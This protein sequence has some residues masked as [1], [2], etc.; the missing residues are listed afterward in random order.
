MAGRESRASN[1]PSRRRLRSCDGPDASL[2]PKVDQRLDFDDGFLG[3]AGHLD[4]ILDH[5]PGA[6][7]LSAGVTSSVLVGGSSPVIIRE[8]TRSR[9][10]KPCRDPLPDSLY[11][12]FHRR[13]RKEERSM[14]DAERVRVLLE[15]DSLKALLALLDSYTWEAHLPK[16]CRIR[17]LTD[18]REYEQKKDLTID[19]IKRLLHKNDDWRKRWHNLQASIKAYG[20]ERAEECLKREPSTD[21]VK[22]NEYV[23]PI[24]E[25][26]ERRRKQRNTQ[27]GVRFRLN[28]N[29]GFLIV[30]D[31]YSPP[32]MVSETDISPAPANSKSSTRS[33]T[34][35]G[36]NLESRPASLVSSAIRDTTHRAVR[37]SNDPLYE[38]TIEHMSS[39]SLLHVS[40]HNSTERALGV[41][42]KQVFKTQRLFTIPTSIRRSSKR[43]KRY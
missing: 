17:D 8:S 10:A 4:L 33:S 28:L 5:T 24:K 2:V 22:E 40:M 37:A 35:Q 16:I 30:I 3:Y 15:I 29:N 23:I 9:R 12:C 19:H 43:L 6:D 31:P 21:Y 18:L 42:V 27:H 13:M 26:A 7:C 39:E 14:V 25:L 41:A 20:N 38:R 34:P 11:T 32:Q 1:H 36:A